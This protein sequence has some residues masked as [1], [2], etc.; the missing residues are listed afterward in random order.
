MKTK[1]QQIFFGV[2]LTSFLME[3]IWYWK[4][5][6]NL[7]TLT[8]HRYSRF[9]VRNKIK[10]S[11]VDICSQ[12][13]YFLLLTCLLWS[14]RTWISLQMCIHSLIGKSSLLHFFSNW[15]PNDVFI[16]KLGF[17]TKLFLAL[18][19]IA[20]IRAPLAISRKKIYDC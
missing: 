5:D 17:L 16:G 3:I 6:V 7:M 10:I 15:T 13:V 11:R 9:S 2:V 1:C 4:H 8:N 14:E 12:N 19:R 18:H 20:R